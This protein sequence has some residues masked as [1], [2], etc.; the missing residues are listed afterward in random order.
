MTSLYLNT[1][2]FFQ[3]II[4]NI[5][6][7]NIF[8]MRYVDRFVLDVITPLDTVNFIWTPHSALLHSNMC[9]VIEVTWKNISGRELFSVSF[10]CPTSTFLFNYRCC[11]APF[12]PAKTFYFI[13]QYYQHYTLFL[14]SIFTLRAKLSIINSVN[15]ARAGWNSKY[16]S[17]ILFKYDA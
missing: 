14:L 3:Q 8:S 7:L 11:A 2:M 12:C 6:F 5:K 16:R 17:Y 4:R 10:Y 9:Y 1:C 15:V 13:I